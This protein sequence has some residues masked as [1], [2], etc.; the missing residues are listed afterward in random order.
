MD[1]SSKAVLVVGAARPPGIGRATAVRL[2]RAGARLVLADAVAPADG[3]GADGGTGRA[4]GAALRAVAD[5]VAAA[6]G[7]PVPVYDVDPTDPASVAELVASA[8]REL[9]RLDACC[10]LVGATGAALGDGLLAEVDPSAWQRGLDW[11]LTTAWLIARACVPALTS[12]GGGSI[13]TLSSYAGMTP[14]IGSG[15][16]GVARAAVNHLTT[17]LARELGPLGIRCNTVCPLGVHPG[18]PRF[19][20]PGLVK[21]AEREGTP[22]SDWLARTIPLGRGQSADEVAAV[23][24]FLVS[25]AASFVSGVNVPVAGGAPV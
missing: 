19:P 18:D 9:G 10:N 13:V 3:G 15:V 8:E 14:V 16:V 20:N 17:V 4:D 21:I 7:R 22:L 1:L 5:E 24:Q 25:D 11:N 6:G 12:A 2:A 23:V